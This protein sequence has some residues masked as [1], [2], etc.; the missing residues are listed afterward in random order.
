MGC[1]VLGLEPEALHQ[2]LRLGNKVVELFMVNNFGCCSFHPGT[3]CQQQI[4]CLWGAAL[5]TQ[6]SR[7]GVTTKCKKDRT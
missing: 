6:P 7:P 1:A 5:Q 3:S 4:A 2:L